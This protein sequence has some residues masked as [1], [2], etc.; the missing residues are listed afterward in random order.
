LTVLGCSVLM[1]GASFRSDVNE[2][3]SGNGGCSADAVCTNIDGSR[4]CGC[5]SGFLGN[6]VNCTGESCD[7]AASLI[8]VRPPDINECASNHGNCDPLAACI[9]SPGSFSCGGCPA[10]YSGTGAT[11]CVGAYR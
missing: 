4:L 1:L 9:N 6:G 2:C 7:P 11:Q 8:V 3:G 5:K 10:G